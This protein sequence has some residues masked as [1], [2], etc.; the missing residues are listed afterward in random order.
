[1]RKKTSPSDMS[2]NMHFK[3]IKCWPR[4]VMA[5]PILKME[6]KMGGLEQKLEEQLN[7]EEMNEDEEEMKKSIITLTTQW[8]K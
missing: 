3:L 7:C 8:G 1:M 6:T 2:G 5:P 4:T